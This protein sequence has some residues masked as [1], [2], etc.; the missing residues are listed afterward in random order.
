MDRF[1]FSLN[2]VLKYCSRI[3]F[4]SSIVDSVHELDKAVVDVI[5]FITEGSNTN[6]RYCIPSSPPLKGTVISK[7]DCPLGGK[8]YF[9]LC[10]TRYMAVQITL[11]P[12]PRAIA[13]SE[14]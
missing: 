2:L 9:D 6:L 8:L 12:I 13:I 5:H 11:Q 14:A 10:L 1:D 7:Y 3:C 4:G